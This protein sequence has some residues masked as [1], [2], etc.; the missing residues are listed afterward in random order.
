MEKTLF[1]FILS[2][3][4]FNCSFIHDPGSNQPI[5]DYMIENEIDSQGKV[6]AWIAENIEYEY[7]MK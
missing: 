6:L 2:L 5:I 7:E 1:L 3:S 4:L